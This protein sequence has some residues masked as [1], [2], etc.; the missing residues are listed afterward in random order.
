MAL[1]TGTPKKKCVK[2]KR[3]NEESFVIEEGHTWKLK[4][5]KINA[6]MANSNCCAGRIISFSA[7]K[8]VGGPHL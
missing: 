4:L 7:E 6:R 8:I 2:L 5:R 1:A 3:F